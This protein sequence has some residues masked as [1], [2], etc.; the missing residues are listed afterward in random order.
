MRLFVISNWNDYLPAAKSSWLPNARRRNVMFDRLLSP[1]LSWWDPTWCAP[2]PPSLFKYN[3]FLKI[4][5]ILFYLICH[6]FYSVWWANRL[7]DAI[8][9]TT[10]CCC[11]SLLD[12]LLN[13]WNQ[14]ELNFFFFFF[15]KKKYYQFDWSWL[16]IELLLWV[17]WVAWLLELLKALDWCGLYFIFFFFKSII[18]KFYYKSSF[19]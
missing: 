12:L 1:L 13:I 19:D 9:L 18:F 4:D 11:P 7:D 2:L 15:I 3:N 10:P 5:S 14:Y 17:E 16:M 6:L 8:R